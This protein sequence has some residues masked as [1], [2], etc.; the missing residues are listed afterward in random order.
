MS[1][2]DGGA[3]FER[4]AA[5]PLEVARRLA[6]SHRWLGLALAALFLG[7]SQ[8]S[9][10]HDTQVVLISIDTLNRSSLAA[11]DS[12]ASNLPN[13]DRFAENSSRFLNAYSTSS[14]TLPAHASL[15]TGLYP[16]R[17]GATHREL[18][19]SSEI[20]TLADSLA[21]GGFETVAFTDGGF[22]APNFGFAR[23]FEYYDGWS[24][25][26]SRLSQLELPRGGKPHRD[27]G[28][29][30]FDRAISFI[31]QHRVSDPPFFLFLQTYAVHNYYRRHPWAIRASRGMLDRS[32]IREPSEYLK[33][34][35][36]RSHCPDDWPVLSQLYRGELVNL[37]AGFGRLMAALDDAGL[38]ASTL[39][40]FLSDHGEGFDFARRRLHH[41]GRLHEDV[42]RIPI[43]MRGPTVAARRISDAISLVDV[44][45]TVLDLV[46]LPV[47]PN[48]DGVSMAASVRGEEARGDPQRYA[49]EFSQWWDEVGLQ[50][51][52]EIRASPLQLAVVKPDLWYIRDSGSREEIYDM[53]ED[54]R[55][56]KNLGGDSES[57]AQPR[58][59]AIRRWERRPPQEKLI[60]D[61]ESRDQLRALGYLD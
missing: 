36:G 23:G 9:R 48:L 20:D 30:L 57:S 19:I 56:S 58:A 29:T 46:G 5:G 12:A 42:I 7:C 14:W 33:C 60:A 40:V 3:V 52:E 13:L 59:L 55:Q 41:G 8:P 11:F 39:V 35:R 53:R 50:S 43:M 51:T 49:M 15:V 47:P 16:D 4:A 31:S 25:E 18:R 17:H 6:P 34:L 24:A 37:D 22:V 54:P 26:G 1:H 38:T 10:E 61:D 44:M 32:Q 21:A 2:G 28:R 45:P 27:P